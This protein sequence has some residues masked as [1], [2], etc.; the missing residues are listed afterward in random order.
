MRAHLEG[1]SSCGEDQRS[2]LA[3]VGRQPTLAS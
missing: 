1:C 2:L 3:L